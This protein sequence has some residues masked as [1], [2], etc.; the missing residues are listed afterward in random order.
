MLVKVTDCSGWLWGIEDEVKGGGMFLRW[1]FNQCWLG[2]GG[3]EMGENEYETALRTTCGSVCG[4]R[5][6]IL[7]KLL[8]QVSPSRSK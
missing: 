6:V 2:V 4:G 7:G 1:S 5:P 3:M 8:I